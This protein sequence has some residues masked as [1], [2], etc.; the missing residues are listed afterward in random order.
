MGKYTSYERAALLGIWLAAGMRITV[1]WTKK[2]FGIDRTT[3]WRDLQKLSRV[4]PIREQDE[5][6]FWMET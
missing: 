3:A 4:L 1:A 2:R 6:Y 5:E